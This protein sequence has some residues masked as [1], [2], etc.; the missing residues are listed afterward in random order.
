MNIGIK[1]VGLFKLSN[2]DIK[3]IEAFCYLDSVIT[4]DDC[5]SNNIRQRIYKAKLVIDKNK[6][7][8]NTFFSFFFLNS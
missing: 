4:K 3:D 2:T 1:V 7:L 6:V 8:T 5:V